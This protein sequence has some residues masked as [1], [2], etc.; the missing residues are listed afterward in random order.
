MHS[1]TTD[2]SWEN[3]ATPHYFLINT[4]WHKHVSAADD[5]FVTHR[6]DWM[7]H[8]EDKVPGE[9]LFTVF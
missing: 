8:G 2:W 5:I 1:V 6:Q 7:I 9:L 3:D 4:E